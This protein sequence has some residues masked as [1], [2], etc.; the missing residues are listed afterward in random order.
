M[1]R[2][3]RDGTAHLVS[4]D[5]IL[6]RERRQGNIHFPYSSDHEQ[7]WQSYPVDPYS[8]SMW[9]YTY[10]E[11]L[12][13]AVPYEDSSDQEAWPRNTGYSVR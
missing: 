6:R 8:C 9:D 1:S 2:L 12:S 3:T 5:Q 7:N 11:S 10:I 13:Q 4:R